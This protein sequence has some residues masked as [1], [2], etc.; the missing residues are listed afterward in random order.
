MSCLFLTEQDVSELIDMPRSIEI[1]EEAFRQMA[2]GRVHNVP[3]TR[4][5]GPGIILHSMSASAEY[6]GL[7]G[8]KNYTTT[9]RGMLF[10][11]AA[12]DI[13]SGEMQILIEAN[14][15]GQLRTGAATGVATRHM[16]RES[17][18]TVGL[19][20]TGLQ[21]R[22]QLMAVCSV[23]KIERV[24]VFGRD[25]DRRRQFAEEMCKECQTE[26]VPV[27][28]SQEAVSGKDIVIAATSSKTPVFDGTDLAEGTHVNAIGGNF[29]QKTEVDGETIR[30]SG[31]IV[32]D[33]IE[34]CRIEAGE[35]VASL[36]EGFVSWDSM[37]DLSD[38]VAGRNPGRKSDDEITFFKSVGLAMEDI[39][40]VGEL[41]KQARE[42]GRGSRAL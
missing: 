6:L 11:V 28:S 14:L 26:V 8:W 31:T 35:F 10:H 36:N 1:V 9:R 27:S 7:I 3:R 15:L 18:S 39:A 4:A 22:T 37:S 38:V 24:E 13:E 40:M 17:S 20:G 2:A 42:Q 19:L 5:Q 30:R 32:C 34:Q 33:S 41:L 23:R 29:L 12:Y 21:A 16:S 25:E